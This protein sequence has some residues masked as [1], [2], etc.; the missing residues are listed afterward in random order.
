M[1]T[2]LGALLVYDYELALV[3]ALLFAV[4]FAALR[5]TVLPGLFALACLPLMSWYLAHRPRRSRRHVRSRRRGPA[6]S[7]PE[8]GDRGLAHFLERRNVHPKQR[9][10]EL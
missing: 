8:P 10:P 2:S 3:F 7:P 5:K 1:A 9:S 6:R 4:A